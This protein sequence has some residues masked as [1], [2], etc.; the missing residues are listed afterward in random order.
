VLVIASHLSL[1]RGFSMPGWLSR[2]YGA[3]GT[4]GVRVFFVISGFLITSLL[5]EEIRKSGRISLGKFFYRRTLRIFPPFYF[6]LLVLSLIATFNLIDAPHTNFLV[7]ITYT[8]NYFS[9]GSWLSAHSWSL[10]VE[11]QFYLMWPVAIVLLGRAKAF[12]AATALLILC[13]LVRISMLVF[14]KS[15]VPGIG[16]HFETVADALATGCLLAGL[17]AWLKE[18]QK[19]QDLL[20]SK[21]FAIVPCVVIA[22]QAIFANNIRYYFLFYISLGITILNVGIALCI[23]WSI[24][25]CDGKIGR[26]LNSRPLIYVGALSYSIYLWQQLFLNTYINISSPWVLLPIIPVAMLSYYLAEKPFLQLRHWL[27]PK[28]FSSQSSKVGNT[29]QALESNRV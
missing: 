21:Y 1:A 18:K 8:S 26:V 4:L 27:E 15:Q 7:P 23:D 20:R 3:A 6:Y 2:P 13:P 17:S 14:F 12:R 19:Y 11:E 9:T 5:L 29:V 22:T 25:N 10:S 24:V 16:S 28:L